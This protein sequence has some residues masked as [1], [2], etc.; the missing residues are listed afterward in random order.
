[1]LALN[2]VMARTAEMLLQLGRENGRINLQ[3]YLEITL[4]F[5]RQD[6]ANLVGTTRETVT[7]M[8]SSLKKDKIIDYDGRKIMIL[9]TD[10]LKL[11]IA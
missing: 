1:N 11:L 2:D 5:S 8:L 3:G 9:N 10:R 6:L 4:E 7:R